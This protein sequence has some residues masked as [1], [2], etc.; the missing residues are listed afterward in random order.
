M[1]QE[2]L[3]FFTVLGRPPVRLTA[4]QTAWVL[5]CGEHTIPAIVAAG[6]L[7]PLGDSPPKSNCI[8]YFST[9][10][11]LALAGDRA[12]LSRLTNAIQERWRNKNYNGRNGLASPSGKSAVISISRTA[13]S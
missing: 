1:Q 2:Q 9:A 4:Q 5:N 11:V 12:K 10:E 13:R 8:K 6:V 7:K 3:Q